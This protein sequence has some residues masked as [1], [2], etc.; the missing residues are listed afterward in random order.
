MLCLFAIVNYAGVI[1]G[2]RLLGFTAGGLDA[3]EDVPSF[4]LMSGTFA[5]A[6]VFLVTLRERVGRLIDQLTDAASTDPLTGLLNR[7][8]F[9]SVIDH[10]LARSERGGRSFSLLIVRLRL[11]QGPQ[12]PA[13]PSRG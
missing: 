13:R 7:R 10:E 12:R 1:I 2:S 9:Q 4:V 3:N 5:V 6:G 8:G 11:L